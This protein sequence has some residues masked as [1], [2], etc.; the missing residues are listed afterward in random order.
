MIGFGLVLAAVGLG[1]LA[2]AGLSG[3]PLRH[4]D[5]LRGT[6]VAA[7]VAAAGA[8]AAEAP[9]GSAVA[10]TALAT[11]T[12]YSW[13]LLRRESARAGEAAGR[14]ALYAL[15][16]LG[17]GLATGLVLSGQW[18]DIAGDRL[19]RWLL[20]LPYPVIAGAD[21]GSFSLALGAL[22]FL[23]SSANGAVRMLLRAAGGPHLEEQAEV[24]RGGRV[25]GV[26]E[27]LLVFGLAVAGQLGA[28]ALVATAKGVLRF[29]ELSKLPAGPEVDDETGLP[30]RADYAT[31]YFLLGSLSSW[32][33][34][35]SAAV[36]F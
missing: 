34:A 15:M 25:I 4:A 1:D 18:N 33:L 29:P 7:A 31:E 23:T 19:D 14:L 5:V 8:L 30:G 12:F 32:S 11:V 35:L 6:A 3:L 24:L 20:D 13:A 17:L 26:L 21:V 28:A 2:A 10:V 9:L 36:L 22:A 27:R 16:A